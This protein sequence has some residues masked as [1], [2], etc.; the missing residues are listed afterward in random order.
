[1]SEQ[2]P[3]DL[4]SA[5][6]PTATLHES[7]ARRGALPASIKPVDAAMRLCGPA[8]TAST[9]SGQ[10][11]RIHEALNIAARGDVLVVDVGEGVEYGYWGEIMTVA[12]QS[13]GLGGLVINGGVRDRDALVAHGFPIFSSCICIRGT[14]KD[15]DAP[16]AVN[17]PIRIGDVDIRAGDLVVG[18]ADGV[19]VIERS[20]VAE[21]VAAAKRREDHEAGLIEQARS[22]VPTLVFISRA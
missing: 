14:G 13:R 15:P 22:G 9:S 20:S 11:L 19:V 7:Y 4:T 8:I 16:G 10:N 17:E 6:M 12:A 21:V 18:D 3:I 5:A 2:V 1:M